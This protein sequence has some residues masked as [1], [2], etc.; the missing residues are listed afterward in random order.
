MGTWEFGLTVALVGS[1]GTLG[2]AVAAEPADPADKEDIPLLTP[3][4]V[5][6]AEAGIQGW[7]GTAPL[8]RPWIPAPAGMTYWGA[9]VGLTLRN[10]I[11]IWNLRLFRASW[12]C[13]TA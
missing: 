11:K 9:K 1:V 3:Q 5:I 8:H 4:C 12:G 2:G 10:K 7:G 6:P 13:L